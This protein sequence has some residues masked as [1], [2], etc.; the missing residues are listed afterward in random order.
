MVGIAETDFNILVSHLGVE[1]R[2]KKALRELMATGP[3]ATPTLR[4]GL[5]HPDPEVRVGCCKVLDHFLDEEALPELI[6]NLGHQD[7]TVRAWAMHALA[8]DR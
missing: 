4:R 5:S 8:C 1:H 6:D 2:A 7:E 3:A